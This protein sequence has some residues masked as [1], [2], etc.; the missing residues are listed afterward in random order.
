MLLC[1]TKPNK[2]NGTK[3]VRGTIRGGNIADKMS[4]GCKNKRFYFTA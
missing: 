1:V 2:T 3:D 4:H